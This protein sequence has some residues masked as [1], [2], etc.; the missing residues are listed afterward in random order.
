M[1]KVFYKCL[2]FNNTKRL[3]KPLFFFHVPKCAGT[4]FAVLISHLFVKTHR[5]FGPL[6]KNNDKGGQTA[7]EN[8]L[9]N[10]KL[11]NNNNLQFLYGHIPFEIYERLKKKYF[12]ISILRDPIERCISHYAWIINRGICSKKDDI[13]ELFKKNILPRNV[14]TN[15]FSGIGLTDQNSS[16]SPILALDNL[17]NKI[18]LLIKS[19]DLFKLLNFII[20]AYNLPNLFFQNQQVN[21]NKIKI[22]KKNIEKIKSYNEQDIIIYSAL[23]QNNIFENYDNKKYKDRNIVNYLYSSPNILVNNKKSILL[24]KNKIKLI[25]KNLIKSNYKIQES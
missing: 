11:I 19:E 15:Q 18:D 22:S 5:L 7:Y 8:Y 2:G 25:E 21:Y 3:K 14:I 6:F 16:E 24:N 17:K 10:E 20:S 9:E 13:D 1:D 23:L 4:T 12:F